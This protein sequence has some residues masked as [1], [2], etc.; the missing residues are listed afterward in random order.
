MSNEY[1]AWLYKLSK[2]WAAHK[3]RGPNQASYS[4]MFHDAMDM[5]REAMNTSDFP[6]AP[7]KCQARNR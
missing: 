4:A 2:A 7:G 6:K 1:K 5:V 3:G